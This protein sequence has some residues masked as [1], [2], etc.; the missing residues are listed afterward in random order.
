MIVIF[1]SKPFIIKNIKT[2]F[3]KTILCICN[4]PNSGIPF[5]AQPSIL[6]GSKKLKGLADFYTFTSDMKFIKKKKLD[7]ISLTAHKSPKVSCRE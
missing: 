6:E 2:K 5:K 7:Y 3:S 4:W 1:K